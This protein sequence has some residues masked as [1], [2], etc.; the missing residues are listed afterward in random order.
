MIKINNN[1][2]EK[3]NYYKS[4]YYLVICAPSILTT[5]SRGDAWHPGLR[6]FFWLRTNQKEKEKKKT[7]TNEYF[8]SNVFHGGGKEA[9][10]IES[11]LGDTPPSWFGIQRSNWRRKNKRPNLLW[12]TY[13]EDRVH[14]HPAEGL[15]G[16]ETAASNP[17]SDTTWNLRCSVFRT[18]YYHPVFLINTIVTF[19]ITTV[20]LSWSASSWSQ[21]H[22]KKWICWAER[23]ARHPVLKCS[24]NAAW[25]FD[26][27]LNEVTYVFSL[28]FI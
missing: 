20:Q 19:N 3:N 22:Q 24:K 27:M 5:E 23:I 4:N 12:G 28:S 9:Q 26:R 25:M 17:R 15:G 18:M 6:S 10:Q 7:H 14:R 11:R 2:M 21:F 1:N 16:L 13:S 8:N